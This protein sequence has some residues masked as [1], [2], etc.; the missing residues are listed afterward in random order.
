MLKYLINSY[1]HGIIVKLA[2]FR[3]LAISKIGIKS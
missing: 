2:A 1:W 3:S